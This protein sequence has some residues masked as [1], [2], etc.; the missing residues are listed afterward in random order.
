METLIES[1]LKRAGEYGLSIKKL[2]SLTGSSKN[3]IK[4]ILLNSKFVKDTN[5]MIHG[6]L[7]QKIR[8]YSYQPFETS[9]IKRKTM[10]NN[11]TVIE[12]LSKK[13]I[14]EELKNISES[15]SDS[16]SENNFDIDEFELINKT[17]L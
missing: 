16:G 8:V 15:E 2:K 14:I 10:K 1:H 5:P 9:Y 6:S 4:T 3:R 13:Q 17:S 11:K 7:K 12:S